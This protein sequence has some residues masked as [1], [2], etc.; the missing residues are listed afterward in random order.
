MKHLIVVIAVTLSHT[1]IL[2]A[3]STALETWL[4]QSIIGE[5]QSQQDVIAFVEARVAVVPQFD[6]IE[7]WDHYS[8]SLRR[9]I[10]RNVVLR[11]RAKT[12][13]DTRGEVEWLETIEGGPGYSIRKLRFEPVPGLWVP[14]LLYEPSDLSGKVPVVMNVNG[15]DGEGKAA[16]YKQIRCINQAKRGMLALNLEWLGMGQLRTDGFNHYRMNQLDLCGTSGVAP[17]YLSMVRGLDVLL[18][19]E[20]ADPARVAV[21]GLSGGGWQTIFFSSLD[22]RVTLA[23]PVAGY[24]SFITRAHHTKDLGD[25]EQTPSDLG[26]IADYTHLTMLLAP[27][28]A[29]L[30]YNSK[31][32]CCFESGYALPPLL[33]AARPI[34]KLYDKQA[35]LTHH[36]NDEPGDH[37]FGKDNRQALY[38][39]LSTHFS[40]DSVSPLLVDEIECTGELKTKE[41]LRVDLPAE[42]ADFHSLAIGL[43]ERLNHVSVLRDVGVP[44]R[45]RENRDRLAE[46]VRAQTDWEIAAHEIDSETIGDK[47]ATHWRLRIADQWTVPVVEISKADPQITTI[48]L[49]DQ[50][51]K[52]V[53]QKVASLVD[54]GHRVI[55][56]DPFYFGESKIKERDFLYAL[57]V[58]TVGERP[59]GIQSSQI[60]AVARWLEKDRHLKNVAVA[61]FGKRA[62]LIALIAAALETDAITT[63][64][65]DGSY[66]SLRQ[67]IEEDI[68]FNDAPELFCFGL[69]KEFD[70]AQIA[71]LVVPRKIS[72]HNASP[73]VKKELS[74]LVEYCR[75]AE[76]RFEPIVIN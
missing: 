57:Q 33:D 70:I 3:D 64:H 17:F 72:F 8:S 49:A 59:L 69:F 38:R 23:N 28:P 44:S 60:S 7:Y 34:Y 14:A 24:S 47:T 2:S 53:T 29:L 35:N 48:V 45:Q 51:R 46:V 5:G 15:H 73:R 18:S 6:S 40:S 22:T 13:R 41:D 19:H 65:L 43:A 74:N 4:D 42:N 16:E 71:A 11:G 52:S 30:T 1:Q 76:T 12:W 25:S 21:A 26:A 55:A 36:V 54:Q 75:K 50:G 58:A 9:N 63:L 20:H 61:A 32:N 62:S 39:K 37:N 68:A 67:V 66:G 10:L 56:V 27:R 31:D